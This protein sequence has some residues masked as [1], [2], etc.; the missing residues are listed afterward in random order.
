MKS[1]TD[2][3]SLRRAVDQLEA[4]GLSTYAARTFTALV[5]LDSGTA[6]DVN[7]AVDVP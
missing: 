6:R 4:L 5:A 3:N 7:D 1:N 2:D